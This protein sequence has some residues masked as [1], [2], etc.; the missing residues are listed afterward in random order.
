M[1]ECSLI[2]SSPR[3][4]CRFT[5]YRLSVCSSRLVYLGL[6]F[7]PSLSTESNMPLQRCTSKAFSP[8]TLP[9]RFLIFSPLY[10]TTQNTS[11]WTS[12]LFPVRTAVGS[13]IWHSK[14]IDS[15]CLWLVICL[16]LLRLLISLRPDTLKFLTG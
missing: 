6:R 3:F 13:R 2:A 15:F 8:M 10:C 16:N 12:S 4:Y 9:R 11:F 5:L 7:H 14:E 1:N